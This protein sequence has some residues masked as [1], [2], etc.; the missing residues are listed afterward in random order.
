MKAPAPVLRPRG[1]AI[2]R[3]RIWRLMSFLSVKEDQGERPVIISWAS[4]PSAHLDD[5][6]TT[7]TGERK[8]RAESSLISCCCRLV[9]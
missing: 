6:E 1:G 8:T 9:N 4:T 3:V 5:E 7:T 2:F